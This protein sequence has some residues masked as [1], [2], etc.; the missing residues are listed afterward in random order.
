MMRKFPSLIWSRSTEAYFLKRR[1]ATLCV[2]RRP[3]LPVHG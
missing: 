2:S 1:M 3:I